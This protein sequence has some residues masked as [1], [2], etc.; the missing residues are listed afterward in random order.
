MCYDML[1]RRASVN[2]SETAL[3]VLDSFYSRAVCDLRVYRYAFSTFVDVER[4]CNC[5]V[6]AEGIHRWWPRCCTAG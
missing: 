2:T 3:Y 1:E 5:E 4:C 6:G